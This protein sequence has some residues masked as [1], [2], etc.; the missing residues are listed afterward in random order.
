MGLNSKDINSIM[1]AGAFAFASGFIASLLA[2]GGFK[3]DIGWEGL[4]SMLA[5][6]AVAG[7]NVALFAVY[8]F[9]KTDDKD[10]PKPQA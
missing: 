7:V 8:R 2:Q 10:Q 1:K 4:L 9:F 5:G 6:A 3:T